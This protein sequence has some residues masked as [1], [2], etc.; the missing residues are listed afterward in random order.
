VK[1]R[2]IAAAYALL[3]ALSA[4]LAIALRDGRVLSHPDPV[5]SLGPTTATLASLGLG[6]SLAGVIIGSS[7]LLVARAEWAG[8]L[9]RELRPFARVLSTGQIVLLS[10]FSSLGEELF[11][12]SLLTPV[13]GVILSGVLF[14]LV[15]QV[16][17]PSRWWWA[18]W[19][20][21][22]GVLLG[23]IYAVTGSLV[24]PLVCHAL[25]N[26]RNLLFLRDFEPERRR[27]PLGGLFGRAPHAGG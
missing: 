10:V 8:R 6:V 21:I 2:A 18:G 3:A 27:R 11:F 26:G 15:H 5:L 24:G 14:G 9:A 1:P 17:G 20:A 16:R 19:A 23:A 13:L 12:R 7:R 22:V 25:V 4:G